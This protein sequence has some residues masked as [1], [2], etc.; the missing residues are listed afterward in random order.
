MEIECINAKCQVGNIGE[1]EDGTHAN[2]KHPYIK[3]VTAEPEYSVGL[4]FSPFFRNSIT[5]GAS[6]L[7]NGRNEQ[8]CSKYQKN[9]TG[10]GK[11]RGDRDIPEIGKQ[12]LHQHKHPVKEKSHLRGIK[13]QR[14]NCGL[15]GEG[16]SVFQGTEYYECHYQ[17]DNS[18][19]DPDELG[20]ELH[21]QEIK[22]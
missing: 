15:A 17:S 7:K 11:G 3:G 9:G 1:I 14:F 4:E 22:N 5:E 10:P 2:R 21:S 13:V 6:E 19:C 12:G 16:I 18:E 8:D 20:M